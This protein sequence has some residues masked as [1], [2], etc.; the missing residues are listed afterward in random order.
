MRVSGFIMVIF[1]AQSLVVFHLDPHTNRSDSYRQLRI[2]SLVQADQAADSKLSIVKPVSLT[3]EQASSTQFEYTFMLGWS[4]AAR[5]EQL[6]LELVTDGAGNFDYSI[7]SYA[8]H[9][10]QAQNQIEQAANNVQ[11]GLYSKF[12]STIGSFFKAATAAQPDIEDPLKQVRAEVKNLF[13]VDEAK[14]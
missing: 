13:L 10:D 6:K 3:P 12:S 11:T 7:Q 8:F 4:K 9:H 5:L 2:E 1:G 14:T